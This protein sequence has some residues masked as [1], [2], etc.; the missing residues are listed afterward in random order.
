[1]K[2]K[3]RAPAAAPHVHR[4]RAAVPAA[5]RRDIEAILI[6]APRIQ[7]RV[8]ELAQTISADYRGKDFVI[9][10]LL[11]GTVMFLA[12]LM[13]RLEFPLQL[14]LM[15]VS[16]YRGGT[17]SGKLEFTRPLK[18]SVRDRHVL[19]VDDILDTGK[20]LRAVTAELASLGAASVK[21]CVLLDKPAGRVGEFVA[22]YVGFVVPH[23]FV[24]GYGL[25][26]DEKYRNLPFVGVLNKTV[27]AAAKA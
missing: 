11:N 23:L 17:S 16:S 18:L 1:M 26:Y 21:T 20:T 3:P 6:P 19:L 13:R 24:V 2:P 7:R 27:Y 5:H 25:D 10:A 4:S 14:D 12:D 15:G 9:V 8:T 22:D